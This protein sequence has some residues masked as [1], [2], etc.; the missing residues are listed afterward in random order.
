MN[1]LSRLA[2]ITRRCIALYAIPLM[3][4]YPVGV[5]A[6]KNTLRIKPPAETLSAK[7]TLRIDA[8]PSTLRRFESMAPSIS[9]SGY[10]KTATADKESVF[11]SNNTGE[12]VAGLEFEITYHTP[13]G[14]QLHRRKVKA[15]LVIPDGETRRF[16]FQS[17]DPQHAFHYAHSIESR[18]P[19]SP[20]DVTIRVSALILYR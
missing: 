12:T 15:S 14:E 1:R 10:D 7:S 5:A 2:V 6:R 9:F 20:Y 17:W 4:L 3:L 11:I 8:S 13:L 19:T 16:D 18:R